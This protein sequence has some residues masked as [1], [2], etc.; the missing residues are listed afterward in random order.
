[1][2]KKMNMITLTVICVVC[3]L[4]GFLIV[5]SAGN[6][7]MKD[8]SVSGKTSESTEKD[9]SAQKTATEPSAKKQ[10][11]KNGKTAKD[12]TEPS[13]QDVSDGGEEGNISPTDLQSENPEIPENPVSTQPLAE[14]P[15]Q[16]QL[17]VD[18]LQHYKGY[19]TENLGDCEQLILVNSQGDSY[20]ANIYCF[21]KRGDTWDQHNELTTD[22]FVGR[23]G[24]SENSY[25][26]SEQTPSGLFPVGEAFSITDEKPDGVKLDWF[27]VDEDIY[28]VDDQYSPYYNQKVNLS[29][30]G[31]VQWNSAEHMIDYY[32]AYKYGF[33]INF[34]MGNNMQRGKGSAIFF[35]ISY[36]GT[37]GCVGVSEPMMLAYLQFLDKNK[38]PYILMQSFE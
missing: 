19:T 11:D 7:V 1:M 37:A 26:G 17:L 23:K 18:T 14:L 2:R 4:V 33:V 32:D 27:K 25:E 36:S 13:Q 8:V 15:T 35:H 12:G 38:N 16:P 5:F 21:E 3:F 9:K 24:I 34:N 10:T 31:S 30:V 22:G 20:T 28:W 29:K 6:I